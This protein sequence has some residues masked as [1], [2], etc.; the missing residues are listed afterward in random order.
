MVEY[1]NIGILGI[2]TDTGQILLPIRAT[3]KKIDLIN[4]KLELIVSKRA[5]ADHL[6]RAMRTHHR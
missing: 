1:W 2:K 3:T 5:K 4:P 6:R